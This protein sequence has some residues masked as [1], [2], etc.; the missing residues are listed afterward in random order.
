MEKINE[1]KKK[2]MF[3]V[4]EYMADYAEDYGIDPSLAY[5]IGLLHDIGYLNGQMGHEAAGAGIL[6]DLGVSQEYL[7]VICGHRDLQN[8]TG[9]PYE[10][11][12]LATLLVEA[13]MSVTSGSGKRVFFKERLNKL[14]K[15]YPDMTVPNRNIRMIKEWRLK[16]HHSKIDDET[17]IVLDTLDNSIH[18]DQ[19]LD[20]LSERILMR[21]PYVKSIEGYILSGTD[22][23]FTLTVKFTTKD[24]VQREKIIKKSDLNLPKPLVSAFKNF[25]SDNN[26]NEQEEND[27]SDAFTLTY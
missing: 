20:F 9:D 2:H 26:Q 25:L 16:E 15:R 18:H 23:A 19:W 8:F 3:G 27:I 4:A 5:T 13:D 14:S 6:M 24:D 17:G 12:N 22:K 11:R 1:G 10:T 7:D 21:N